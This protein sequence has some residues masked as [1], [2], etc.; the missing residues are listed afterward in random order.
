MAEKNL[1]NVMEFDENTGKYYK[2]KVKM[3][4]I[5]IVSEPGGEYLHHFVPPEAT[6]EDKPAKQIA[7]VIV[8]WL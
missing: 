7:K 5:V 6:T 2:S 3:E 1:T 4:H 8:D